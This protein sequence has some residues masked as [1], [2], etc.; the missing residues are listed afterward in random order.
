MT[1]LRNREFLKLRILEQLNDKKS[2]LRYVLTGNRWGLRDSKN[3]IFYCNDL[4]LKIV[5][6]FNSDENYNFWLE[7][8]DFSKKE[9]NLFSDISVGSVL[10]YF[11][12]IF[13]VIKFERNK[14]IFSYR[15]SFLENQ[16]YE[17]K[18]KEDS[19]YCYQMVFDTKT[20]QFTHESSVK[21]ARDFIELCVSKR[22]EGRSFHH[23]YPFHQF[24]YSYLDTLEFPD[25]MDFE[26][27]ELFKNIFRN[28][29]PDKEHSMTTMV[30]LVSKIDEHC[31]KYRKDYY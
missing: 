26:E 20:M 4:D 27:R 1:E 5:C 31:K 29:K 9:V 15:I 24:K 14:M 7:N 22:K 3:R 6:E 28:F 16:D 18:M 30:R 11:G 21:N 13:D 8:F 23:I 12:H 25:N 17:F 19:T 2:P 10:F